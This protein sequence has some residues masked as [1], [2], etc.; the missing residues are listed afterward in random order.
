[1]ERRRKRLLRFY[2]TALRRA[3]KK[4]R[5]RAKVIDHNKRVAKKECKRNENR[6]KHR[7]S[8]SKLQFA[9]HRYRHFKQRIAPSDFSI[10]DNCEVFVG[11][12][13]DLRKDYRNNRKVFVNM[14]SV[15]KVTNESLCLL[16]SIMMLFR[17]RRID[18]D[19]SFPNDSR[20]CKVVIESGFFEIL[21]NKNRKNS[22][23]NVSSQI[24]THSAYKSNAD[25][26]DAI[27]LSSSEF[28][29]KEKC[30]CSG[31]YNAF[32]ELMSNTIEHADEIAGRQKWWITVTKDSEKEKV[33]F[34]F[35]DYGR[36]IIN[37]LKHA[38]QKRYKNIVEK[39]M[40]KWTGDDAMLLKEVMEGAL[41]LSE[42]DG[43]NYGN[44]LNSIYEDMMDGQI[45]NVVIISNGVFADVKKGDYHKINV[46][47]PGTF[48]CWEINK[49]TKH[50]V[51][52]SYTV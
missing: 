11:F 2:L 30:N 17:D 16:L 26:A 6:N 46:T 31:V 12:I 43:D 4:A 49:N 28:L 27:I 9:R 15:N 13:N 50:E 23:N 3:K 52:S 22:I 33:T 21:Y 32:L 39:I 41:K 10:I 40:A 45:D 42:K 5:R 24:Y 19:G 1:M 35:L 36:G 37:T 29:W 51:I 14:S 7:I 20:A 25:I 18:F 47:F 38:E 48:I 34:S 8:K 44:G